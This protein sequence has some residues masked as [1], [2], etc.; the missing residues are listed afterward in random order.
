[1]TSVILDVME[2][3]WV[4]LTVD[5]ERVSVVFIQIPPDY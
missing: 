5:I 1:M 2:T 4:R 3:N